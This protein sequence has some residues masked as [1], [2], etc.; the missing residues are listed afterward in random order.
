MSLLRSIAN[1]VRSMFRRE[2]FERELDEELGAFLEMAVEEKMKEGMNR[3]EA[4]RAVRLERGSLDVTKE[5]V[6]AA[7]WESL[8]EECWQDL[9]F[10]ARMLRKNPGFATAAIL[11]LAL[12]IGA[13]TAIFSVVN[14]VLLKPLPYRDPGK[15]VWVDEYWP[16]LN[17]TM[18][19]NPEYTNWKLHNHTFDEIAAY[20]GGSQ[21]NVVGA[22]EP[23][24]VECVGITANFLRT[25][26]VRPAAGRDFLPEEGRPGGPLAAI[27]QETN[28]RPRQR[29]WC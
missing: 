25:L 8:L 19:P 23:E 2:Q 14:K 24:R 17:D 16:R 4:L 5:V 28:L 29:C 11:T 22:G 1:G 18:V 7:G 15:L 21:M 13:N 27:G 26:G 6:H 3:Q 10:G 9:R 12:G 20:D